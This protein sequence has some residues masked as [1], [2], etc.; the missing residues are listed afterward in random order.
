MSW[1]V[2]IIA[3]LFEVV[4]VTGIQK[5]AKGKKRTGFI[6]L[7]GGFI[8]SFTLLSIAM[9][10]IPLGVA[11]AVWTGMGTVGSAIVGMIFYNE[12]TDRLR[13]VFMGMVIT[14]VV[15]LRLVSP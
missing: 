11:Y 5:I 1:L 8:I 7:I 4:G 6:F 2:L 12:S 13:L 3:G 15:G 14:A 9:E 10:A